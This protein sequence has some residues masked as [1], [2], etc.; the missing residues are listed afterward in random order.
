MA[1]DRLTETI[2]R[3]AAVLEGQPYIIGTD[4]TVMKVLDL[5]ADGIFPQEIV[6]QKYYPNLKLDQVYT[7][8]AFASHALKA[9]KWT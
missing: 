5:L 3:N 8:I 1:V 4:I 6:T 9:I 7:C 2:T